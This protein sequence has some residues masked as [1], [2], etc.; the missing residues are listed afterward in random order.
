MS[1]SAYKS[2]INEYI[3]KDIDSQETLLKIKR[4][5][6]RSVKYMI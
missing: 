4:N 6:F 3:N 2:S 5:I 1:F